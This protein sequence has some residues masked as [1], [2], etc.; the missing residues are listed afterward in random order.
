MTP[1]ALLASRP[2]LTNAALRVSADADGASATVLREAVAPGN[3]IVARVHSFDG[4]SAAEIAAEIAALPDL[5]R[6]RDAVLNRRPP[7]ELLD[8]AH[9]AVPVRR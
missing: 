4:V 1:D 5:L 3:R 9:T 2:A 6:L 7:S 8:L